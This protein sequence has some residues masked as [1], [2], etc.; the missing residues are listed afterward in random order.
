MSSNSWRVW[1][2]S[3]GDAYIAC[4]DNYQALK[5]SLHGQKWR[6][7]YT[8]ESQVRYPRLQ[9]FDSDRTWLKWDRPDP[10][11]GITIAF[12]ILLLPS[13]L[14]VTPSMRDS[15]HWKDVEFVPGATVGNVT[16]A[17]VTLNE[18]GHDMAIDGEIEQ[19]HGFLPLHNGGKLQL[20]IHH[21]AL[22][23]DFLNGLAKG[24]RECRDYAIANTSEIPADGRIFAVGRGGSDNT[25]F[26]FEA[27][28]HRPA[29]DPLGFDDVD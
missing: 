11:G 24:F 21:E 17:T 26:S 7:G 19:F 4:R 8:Q 1:V 9:S 16:I 29:D 15:R 27:N 13:E 23:T 18:P 14:A 6:V 12:R 28:L 20:T 2:K 10:V 3:D 25:P 5:V 22:G